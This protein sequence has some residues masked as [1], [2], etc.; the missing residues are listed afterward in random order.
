MN[1]GLWFE[2]RDKGIVVRE[3]WFLLSGEL[4]YEDFVSKI[5]EC[6]W[7]VV[8]GYVV[9][10]FGIIN[11]VKYIWVLIYV[12]GVWLLVDVVYYVLYLVIGV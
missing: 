12:V 10:I 4:D 8:M 9:N 11:K 1:C 7:L 5:N 3:I 6:I 2:L